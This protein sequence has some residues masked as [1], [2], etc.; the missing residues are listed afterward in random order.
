MPDAD[1]LWNAGGSAAGA[2]VTMPL[3]DQFW[4]ERYGQVKD[5]FGHTLVDR[6]AVKADRASDA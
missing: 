5:P 6:R 4:G 1:A 3:E 2:D